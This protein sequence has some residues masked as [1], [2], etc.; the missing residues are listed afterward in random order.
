MARLAPEKAKL[1][2]A[3]STMAIH[4]GVRQRLP[5]DTGFLRTSYKFALENGGLTG[6]VYSDS[7]YSIYIEFGTKPHFP[8]VAPLEEWARR[9]G[10]PPGTGFLIA[11]KISKTG[12]KAVPAL[13]PAY[14]AERSQFE[15]AVKA[16]LQQAV[17]EAAN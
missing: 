1:A 13:F 17:I 10:M 8:P 7:K 11:R 2:V 12:T 6:T 3:K 4:S 16:A 14:E 15:A 5:V 9:H